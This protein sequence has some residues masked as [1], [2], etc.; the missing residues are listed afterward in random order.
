MRPWTATL[1]GFLFLM[2][3]LQ[4]VSGDEPPHDVEEHAKASAGL[5]DGK[6]LFVLY[7]AVC[8][9]ADGSGQ[10]PKANLLESKPADLTALSAQNNGEFPSEKVADVIRNGGRVLGHGTTDMPAWGRELAV[11]YHPDRARARISALVGYI[12]TLQAH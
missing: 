2:T 8:H 7:C 3:A 5:E 4:A 6:H 1:A 9:G 11:R 10:G 12:R